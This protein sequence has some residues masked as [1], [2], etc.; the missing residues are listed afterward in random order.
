MNSVFLDTVGLLALWDRSDQWHQGAE[1]AF[2]SLLSA[3]V[4]LITTTFV[5]LET[6]NAASRRPYRSDVVDL[7]TELE[8]L[9][10]L[11]TPTPSDWAAAWLAYREGLANQ[12]GIIDQTSFIVM[13]RLG[14]THAFTNDRH[15][16]AAGLITLF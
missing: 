13:R 14:I 6:G 3:R 1:T 8:R 2:E 5:M 11:I 12:A 9:G 4:R 16:Q 7:K 10:N 15:F